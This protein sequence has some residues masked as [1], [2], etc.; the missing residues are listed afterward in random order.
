MAN[1]ALPFAASGL[2]RVP[3]SGELNGGYPCGP[4]DEK[5][6]NWLEWWTT[7]QIAKVI[8]GA[9]LA[10]DDTDLERLLKAIRFLSA[11]TLNQGLVNLTG[12]GNFVASYTGIHELTAI[13][14]GGGGG[15]SISTTASA[16]GGGGA[17]GTSI[18]YVSLVAGVSYP[19]I[20]GA[21]GAGGIGGGA[22]AQV[23]GTTSFNGVALA[24][25]GSPGV[26]VG[27]NQSGGGG[28]P[29]YGLAPGASLNYL[30][31]N[32]TQGYGNVPLGASG[33]NA[34]LG[35]FGGQLTQQGG[36][37]GSAPGGGGGG[38]TNIANGG[39]GAAGSITVRW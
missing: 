14:G 15:S 36:N 33:G 18:S 24:S 19:Y 22:A 28:A 11:V 5:L 10:V 4:L 13:G 23:G 12:S 7:G 1:I 38:A 20:C 3:N 26:S 16:A 6:D 30:G 8:E 35:G 9:G 32:G 37:L 31:Q 34:V 21:G 17:G 29:G 39:A 25:G 2:R 27:A